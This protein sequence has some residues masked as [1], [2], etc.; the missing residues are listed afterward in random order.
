MNSKLATMAPGL[1]NLFFSKEITVDGRGLQ[2]LKEGTEKTANRFANWLL[3]NPLS[4]NS[5]KNMYQFSHKNNW[6][7]QP[8]KSLAQMMSRGR[9]RTQNWLDPNKGHFT[10]SGKPATMRDAGRHMWRNATNYAILGA[11]GAGML[12]GDPS[13]PSDFQPHNMQQQQQQRPHIP[14]FRPLSFPVGPRGY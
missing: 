12:A 13:D 8:T 6:L 7:R 1:H 11:T 2:L 5:I 14:Q 9:V 10:L 4:K 3:N